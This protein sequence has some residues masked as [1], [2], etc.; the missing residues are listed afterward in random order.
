MKLKKFYFF[1]ISFY[2]G[3]TMNINF[4]SFLKLKIN[5]LLKLLSDLL[6]ILKQRR[7]VIKREYETR[8]RT[9]AVKNFRK[10]I[11]YTRDWYKSLFI[12]PCAFP[13]YYVLLIVGIPLFYF[14][15]KFFRRLRD[16][17]WKKIRTFLLPKN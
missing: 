14:F 2:G 11:Y 8:A 4:M 1:I 6:Q 16:Y 17:I 9:V 13:A 10:I 5:Q 12:F 3:Q 15:I 7:D